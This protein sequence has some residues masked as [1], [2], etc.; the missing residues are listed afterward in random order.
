MVPL[1]ILSNFWGGDDLP[2]IEGHFE[3]VGGILTVEFGVEIM[4]FLGSFQSFN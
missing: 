1:Q 2:D 3:Q 4:L